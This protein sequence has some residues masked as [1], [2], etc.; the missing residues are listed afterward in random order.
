MKFDQFDFDS[1]RNWIK[2]L[3]CSNTNIIRAR[4]IVFDLMR[5]RENYEELYNFISVLGAEINRD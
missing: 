2:K 3:P 5:Y 1:M 4:L